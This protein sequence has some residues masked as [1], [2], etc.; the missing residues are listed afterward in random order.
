MTGGKTAA[1]SSSPM[2]RCCKLRGLVEV[3][4]ESEGMR[5]S[6]QAPLAGGGV[7]CLWAPISY[8]CVYTGRVWCDLPHARS[9]L[10]SLPRSRRTRPAHSLLHGRNAALMS[11]TQSRLQSRPVPVFVLAALAVG[12]PRYVLRTYPGGAM[13]FRLCLTGCCGTSNHCAA[14][15]QVSFQHPG[16]AQ[17]APTSMVHG[18]I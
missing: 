15:W 4:G 2:F 13:R 12:T 7:C 8:R 9:R 10:P 16:Q 3:S 5:A 14:F 11:F 6:T 17:C 1:E 18:L